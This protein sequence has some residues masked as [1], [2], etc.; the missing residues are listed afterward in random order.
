MG[1]CCTTNTLLQLWRQKISRVITPRSQ[2]KSDLSKISYYDA[3]NFWKFGWNWTKNYGVWAIGWIYIYIYIYIRLKVSKVGDRSRGRPEG[4]FFNSYY[5][6]VGRALP[7]S[8]N[9]TT[10]PLIRTLYCWV[11][12]KEVSSTIFKV[13]GMSRPGIKHGSPGPLAMFT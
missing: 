1:K 11:L 7:L 8:L 9:C 6:E 4:S 13:F 12:S 5:T 3:P 10:L 2:H